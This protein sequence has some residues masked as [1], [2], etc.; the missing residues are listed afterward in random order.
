MASKLEMNI[1]SLIV[2]C[3]EEV[4]KDA[5][6]WMVKKYIKSLDTMIKELE[7]SSEWVWCPRIDF[8]LFKEICNFQQTKTNSY[9]WIQ[10]TMFGTEKDNELH[11]T[12]NATKQIEIVEVVAGCEFGWSY[13]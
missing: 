1:R 2:H 4:K 12:T 8:Q 11:R 5:N 13:H 7:A 6:S 10:H 3:E 9:R